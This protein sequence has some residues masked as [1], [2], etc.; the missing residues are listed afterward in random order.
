SQAVRWSTPEAY[1]TPGA[2]PNGADFVRLRDARGRF[3]TADDLRTLGFHGARTLPAAPVEW[4]VDGHPPGRGR[5]AALYPG[6]GNVLDRSIVRPLAVPAGRPT[7]SFDTTW[8]TETGFDSGFVQ[9]STDGGK[10]YTSLVNADTTTDLDPSADPALKENVP[11]FNGKGGWTNEVFDLSRYAGRS[12]LL[13][14][15]YIS[16][17]NTN[18]RGWWIDNVK[19]NDTVVSDGSSLSGWRTRTQV[20][21]TPVAGFT[22]QL[23]AIRAD[24]SR[25]WTSELP[26]TSAFSGTFGTRQ[27]RRRLG[28]SAGLVGALVTY[29]DPREQTTQYARYTL[30]ANG[31]VQP[32][33]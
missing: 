32:G 20:R 15:R 26:L 10:T 18:G 6:T 33:G 22:V 4:T 11:G 21:P 7:L 24:G 16:D 30:T 29:D 17:A 2:P 5:N 3:L 14:F 12:V 1:D 23:V 8:S 9:I 28:G 25:V 27:L 19:V 31:V 13:A